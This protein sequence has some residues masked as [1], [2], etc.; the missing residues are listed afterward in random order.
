[1]GRCARA[2][3][4][5]YFRAMSESGNLSW[6][7]CRVR[8]GS[9]GFQAFCGG[10]FFFYQSSHPSRLLIRNVFSA[11]KCLQPL[12]NPAKPLRL[13]TVPTISTTESLQNRYLGCGV[14]KTSGAECNPDLYADDDNN[15]NH[16][17]TSSIGSQIRLHPS[18][19]EQKPLVL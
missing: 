4:G 14:N 16:R 7:S 12:G 6:G 15:N 19:A 8:F 13:Q 5:S 18:P 10:G 17:V 11:T 9:R 3:F 2:F 1:M